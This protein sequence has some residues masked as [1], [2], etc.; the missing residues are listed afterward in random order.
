MTERT[1]ID[2]TGK[3][4]NEFIG[5]SADEFAVSTEKNETFKLGAGDDK[6]TF[7]A[8][9]GFGTDTVYLAEG[10]SLGLE[11]K[12][13]ETTFEVKGKDVVIKAKN[14]DKTSSVILK[15][16]ASKDLGADVYL[17]NTGAD[18]WD[19]LNLTKYPYS[20]TQKGNAFTGTR[21]NEVATST[22]K[23]ETF[24]LGAGTNT[25][26]FN[27]EEGF[28]T[29]TVTL[30]KQETLNLDIQ[31]AEDISYVVQ[32]KNLV[33]TAKSA[34]K[35]S[36]IILKD[37]AGKDLGATVNIVKG[38][39]LVETLNKHEFET[40]LTTKN[41][42]TGT[43]LIDK[44]D[45]S[46]YEPKSGI[47]GVTIKTGAGDDIITGSKYNDTIVGGTG[48]N[49]LVIDTTE[50]IGK[51]T[52]T[53]TKGETLILDLK[54]T[55]LEALSFTKSGNNLVISRSTMPMGLLK[56][57]DAIIL[58]NYFTTNATVKVAHVVD[59]TNK[60]TDLKEYF[61]VDP[62]D[63]DCD[64]VGFIEINASKKGGSLSDSK[65]NDYIIGS[66]KADKI[67]VTSG[68][69]GIISGKGNDTINIKGGS[70]Y[71]IIEAE[72]G[73]DTI[74]GANKSD[75][76]MLEI[77]SAN[78]DLNFER[79]GNNLVVTRMADFNG[80]KTANKVVKNLYIDEYGYL[81]TESKGSTKVGKD[82]YQI[83]TVGP[84]YGTYTTTKPTEGEEGTD[85]KK[86]SATRYLT[87]FGGLT[88]DKYS[89]SPSFSTTTLKDYFKN[90]SNKIV[91]INDEEV[92]D[93][94]ITVS[95]QKVNYKDKFNYEY[96][97]TEKNDTVTFGSGDDQVFESVGKNTINLGD[98]DNYFAISNAEE[99]V[100]VAKPKVVRGVS[101]VTAGNG[102]DVFDFWSGK[103]TANITSG[104]GKDVFDLKDSQFYDYK[105]YDDNFYEGSKVNIL[106]FSANDTIIVSKEQ[107]AWLNDFASSDFSIYFDV[108]L[109]EN[110]NGVADFSNVTISSD[111]A[112]T[113]KANSKKGS[114]K[115]GINIV[116]EKGVDGAEGVTNVLTQGTIRDNYCNEVTFDT[117]KLDAITSEVASWL[118][119]NSQ[120]S[121]AAAVFESGKADD[122]ASIMNVYQTGEY[123]PEPPT[124]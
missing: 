122:I 25:I 121:S 89:T 37:F 50:A 86:V 41:S 9:V 79:K 94:T 43:A 7:D 74:V 53:M 103:Y 83:T 116:G 113:F 111:T 92:K 66:D 101:T 109:D 124:A 11:I 48:T 6:I 32:G 56:T 51:D 30:T 82:L 35:T 13:A 84:K 4:K 114:F 46:G 54:N 85:Y 65:Y 49:T 72:D 81:T 100:G 70:Q 99:A 90:P 105:G 44:V 34:G 23:K 93:L 67:T 77:D 15:D 76:L 18:D 96:Y 52:Y 27:A 12:N 36:N 117:D 33:V 58:K 22:D 98:G 87:K 95:G 16:L 88:E 39:T 38:E 64:E 104:D 24:K 40:K 20:A 106:D 8:K 68:F 29:D 21:L 80:T 62:L 47:K 59:E 97:G 120:Y 17:I 26:T 31:K 108:K 61:S 1:Q 78:D 119:D 63:E 2:A 107:A 45:A 123:T 71:I 102:D 55:S 110:K 42:F 28:G 10:E 75:M 115:T 5:T 14:E 60:I 19:T 3:K 73:N 91:A 112:D 118:K 69:D 57:D